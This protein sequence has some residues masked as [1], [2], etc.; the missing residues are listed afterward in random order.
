MVLAQTSGGFPARQK[1]FQ[2]TMQL[3]ESHARIKFW[4]FVFCSLAILFA[5][6]HEKTQ[7]Q[8]NATAQLKQDT[9]KP[10]VDIKV[11]RH[12]DDKG[13]MIG[14]DSTYSSYYSSVGGDTVE[15]DSMFRGFNH[16]FDKH[17]Q[18]MFNDLFNNLFFNDTLI[19]QDFFH[20]DFFQERY[21]LNDLYFRDMM[22]RMDSIKNKYYLE[23]RNAPGKQK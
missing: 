11:N 8:N 16:Y 18:S 19:H 7:G 13:N 21:R 10:K 1:V 6:C 2:K 20:N 15:M 17:H 4:P 23:N 12:Y 9:V 22:K 5:S 3:V 14:F